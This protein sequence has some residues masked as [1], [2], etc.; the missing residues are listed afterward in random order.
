MKLVELDLGVQSKIPLRA[1]PAGKRE[2]M[3]VES[4]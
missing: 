1:V 2:I 4:S 3:V